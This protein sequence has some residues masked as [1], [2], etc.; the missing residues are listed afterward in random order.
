MISGFLISCFPLG[1]NSSEA[2]EI[3]ITCQGLSASA[4]VKLYVEDLGK[5]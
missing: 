4:L 2:A 5:L 1:T 3:S